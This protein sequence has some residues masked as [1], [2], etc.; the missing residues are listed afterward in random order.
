M[1]LFA[2]SAS[3]L[4]KEFFE[5]ENVELFPLR[6]HIGN[7][8]FEDIRTIHSLKVFDAI[9]ND[10]RPKTSQVSPDEMLN[11]F[12][13]LAKDGEEGFYIAFSSELSGTYGTAMMASEQI[14][15]EYPDLKLTVLDSKLASLG[16]GMLVKEAVKL[17]SQGHPLKEII[18]R[19]RFMAEHTE[20]LF[21]VEDL[22]YMAKGGR[23]S[24]GSAFVGGLLN[25]KPLL[26]VENGKLVPIEKLR[27][28]KKVIKR[29]VELMEERGEQLEK[30][31]ISISHG[32]DEE[33]ANLMK[34]AIEEQFHP[35]S[36]EIYM[37][38]SVIA[39]HTGP[40]TLAVFFQNKLNS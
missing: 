24:K 3:D 7:E 18:E 1:R 39:A 4:P 32:D 9:R 27:G 34:E 25:I 19:V 29:I 31:I 37:I 33:F 10:I 30:Q 26:H 17:R 6:V 14:R 2:D 12:E 16:Y 38:G 5:K 35:K 22:D 36:V 15:E 11:A 20:S 40:G 13:Q 8:E 21:T 23:I 28:R